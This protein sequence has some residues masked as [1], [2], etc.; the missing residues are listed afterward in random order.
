MGFGEIATFLPDNPQVVGP[1]FGAK[2]N[3]WTVMGGQ[4][5]QNISGAMDEGASSRN[6][7]N[8]LISQYVARP[9][10]NKDHLLI[11]TGDIVFGLRSKSQQ[12]GPITMLNL[13][14]L[15]IVLR[16]GY[17]ENLVRYKEM[18]QAD[19]DFNDLH[20]LSESELFGT[21]WY[22]QWR[23]TH[24]DKQLRPEDD[25][26]RDDGD[27]EDAENDGVIR[28]NEKRRVRIVAKL[29]NDVTREINEVLALRSANYRMNANG[30]AFDR[31]IN[32]N[33]RREKDES[34]ARHKTFVKSFKFWNEKK[35]LMSEGLRFLHAGTIMDHWNFLGIVRSSTNDTGY[36]N[37][38]TNGAGG[39]GTAV[40]VTIC[41]KTFTFTNYFNNTLA[42]GDKLFLILTRADSGEFQFYPWSKGKEWPSYDDLKYIDMSGSI[43]TAPVIYLGR[44]SESLDGKIRPQGQRISASGLKAGQKNL[45]SHNSSVSLDKLTVHVRIK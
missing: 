18:K 3:P 17:H 8:G 35:D 41:K 21:R 2:S 5:P 36:A 22:D 16:Q 7:E 6:I 30:N 10:A 32:E 45:E 37:N 28:A 39:K 42:I 13:G 38:L 27:E 9:F 24:A 23:E 34:M 14:S 44:L 31:L 33:L 19:D 11:V 26:I 29:S 1:P 20:H 12:T 4:S 40:A 15:N 43:A 25:E